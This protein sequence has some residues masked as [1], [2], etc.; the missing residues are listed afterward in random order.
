MTVIENKHHEVL[1]S[2]SMTMILEYTWPLTLSKGLVND[3][4]KTQ[5]VVLTGLL[6]Q[7]L[8]A[9]VQNKELCL[10]LTNYCRG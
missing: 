2:Q 9:L 1:L 3:S 6:Y 8:G 4:A 7:S 10:L 5:T